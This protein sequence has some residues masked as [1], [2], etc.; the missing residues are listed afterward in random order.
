MQLFRTPFPPSPKARWPRRSALAL[1]LALL[2]ATAAAQDA[3]PP[4][5]PDDIAERLRIVE[6]RLGIAADE[7]AARTD[8]AEF[9][10]AQA[11]V[12]FGQ[13]AWRDAVG[14]SDAQPA[15]DDAQ[16]LGDLF[17]SGGGVLRGGRGREQGQQGQREQAAARRA[18]SPGA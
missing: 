13:V 15:F 6:R 10:R 18:G 16:A 2:S 17:G 1:S 7:G 8:L 5:A 4:P 9:D 3:A 11:A 14:R 12:E